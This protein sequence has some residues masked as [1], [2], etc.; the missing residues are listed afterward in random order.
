MTGK[1]EADIE[2]IT[3]PQKDD[4][5]VAR[6]T[7]MAR[8]YLRPTVR[9]CLTITSINRGSNEFGLTNLMDALHEQ[10]EAM[11]DGDLSRVEEMLVAQVHSLDALFN[12]LL[13][14]ATNSKKMDAHMKLALRA[15]SQ[16]R[17]TLEALVNLK[18]PKE[19]TVFQQ[20][21]IAHGPQ[22]VNNAAALGDRHP[23]TASENRK[24]KNKLMEKDD[25]QRL[26]TGTTSP[27]GSADSTM[28]TMAPLYRANVG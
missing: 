6:S 13:Q 15:Q 5:G 18:R 24:S 28:E 8:G 16:C 9:A 3:V 22:Q 10:V 27:T 7:L 25:E 19:L 20:A 26:D 12:T 11:N 21:N 2:T 14:I 23:G 1:A 17:A 4:N